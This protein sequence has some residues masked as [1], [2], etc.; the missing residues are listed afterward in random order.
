[1]SVSH[2]EHFRRVYAAVLEEWLGLSTE[3][4]LGGR[5]ERLSLFPT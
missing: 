2:E 3:A 5:F 4:A 1:M